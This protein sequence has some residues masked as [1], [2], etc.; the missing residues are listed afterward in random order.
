M[1]SILEHHQSSPKQSEHQFS[2]KEHKRKRSLVDVKR[3]VTVSMAKSEQS[4]EETSKVEE[5]PEKNAKKSI[6]PGIQMDL[7]ESSHDSSLDVAVQQRLSRTK[8]MRMYRIVKQRRNKT[9]DDDDSDKDDDET[10][11][12]LSEAATDGILESR[13]SSSHEKKVSAKKSVARKEAKGSRRANEASG[14]SSSKS[15]RHSKRKR[16]SSST[17]DYKSGYKSTKSS[18]RKHRKTKE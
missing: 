6:L 15:S 10:S 3:Q 17:A 11:R 16:A 8:T 2:E 1:C 7:D 5:S 14:R 13:T 12:S 18:P 4:P 9:R